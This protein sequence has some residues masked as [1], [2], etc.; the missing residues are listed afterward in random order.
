LYLL[1][2]EGYYSES[3]DTILREDL[4]DEAM[5]LTFMLI[6]NEQTNLPKVNALYSLMCF[7]SSR[8]RQEKTM[9]G[10]IDLLYDDR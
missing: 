2:S 5:R 6:E 10:V 9:K 1:F 7:H 8:L 4:C 3:D